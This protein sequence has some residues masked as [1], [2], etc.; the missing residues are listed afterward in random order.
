MLHTQDQDK[1]RKDFQL[2]VKG[3]KQPYRSFTRLRTS[4]GSFRAVELSISMTRQDE[5]RDMR[6][7]GTLTDVEERRRA[8]RAL[9]EAERKYR[10]IVENAAGG[11]YQLTPEGFYLSA[12][13]A[14]A[15]VLGYADPDDLLRHVKNANETV[16]FNARERQLFLKELEDMGFIHNYEIQV[17]RKDG[18]RIWVNENA[19]IVKDEAG[20]TLYYEGSLEDI[21]QRKEADIALREAK[22]HS[23]LA[24]RAKSEFLAN[25]SH[26]LRTP[27]NAI[28]GFSEILKNEIFGAIGQ[29]SYKEYARD[30]HESGKKLLTVIN[31]I[32]DISKIEA[33]N[34]HLN[35]Q[36]VDI[37]AVLEAALKLL[38]NKVKANNLIV[39]NALKD[40][41]KIV[42]EELAIKQI[43]L[44]LLSNAIK[45]TPSGGRVTITNQLDAD[46]S[47]RIAITDTGIGIEEGDIGKALSAFGQIDNSF[48]RAGAGTGLGLTLAH[49][50]V[51]L[52]E[53]KLEIF[54]QKGIGTT[55]TIVLPADRVAKKEKPPVV[56]PVHNK[57]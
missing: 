46:G 4:D 24:N 8:E 9:G 25:M 35:E 19:R 54:S 15:R 38:D 33:G 51:K 13:P 44:N 39:V 28:I 36:V 14:L 34:R 30:I 18:T 42:A 55:V 23:D 7:V 12:N 53:G 40:V 48:N 52:H 2:F 5:S 50:L 27:L 31:E 45:F 1:Q 56:S 22:I 11:I 47:L 26:E 6:V 20:A 29:D 16:C 21:S 17:M 10:T 49:A 41:P 43:L 57:E 3:Q 37:Y 32:L